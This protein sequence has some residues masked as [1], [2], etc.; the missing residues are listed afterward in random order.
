VQL[1]RDAE[2]D[3]KPGSALYLP[4][5]NYTARVDYAR[6]ATAQVIRFTNSLPEST[7]VFWVTL[8]AKR[9]TDPLD[10]AG[11]F[12]PYELQR[13]ARARLPRCSFVGMVEAAFYS[14]VGLV[15]HGMQKAVSWHVH[16]L[17]WGV[18]E[19]RMTELRDGINRRVS[20]MVPGVKAA[21]FRELTPDEVE[22][23]ALYMLKAP[24]NEY[25]IYAM[26]KT[27]ADPDT[28][29]IT[30]PTT[31]RFWT[32]KYQLG[33]GDLVRMANIMTGKTLDTVA[34]AAGQGC[35]LLKAINFEALTAYRAA[36]DRERARRQIQRSMAAAQ[37]RSR[38]R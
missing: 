13:W 10:R 18:T 24:V 35:P 4:A 2:I 30:T 28:G 26:K 32:K 3:L 6:I 7:P 12:D 21:H 29:E 19:Q 25:R 16:M 15:L 5:N 11:D 31:G 14:N 17:V 36:E 22:G 33:P 37:T 23:Q 1:T 8:I 27:V 9:F 34:F 20:T 38:Q